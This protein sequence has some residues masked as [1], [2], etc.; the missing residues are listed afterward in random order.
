MKTIEIRKKVDDAYRAEARRCLEDE[1]LKRIESLTSSGMQIDE[2]YAESLAKDCMHRVK[3]QLFRYAKLHKM[4]DVSR[5]RP[6]PT[7]E[8]VF[9]RESRVPEYFDMPRCMLDIDALVPDWRESTAALIGNHI[10][11]TGMSR[12]EN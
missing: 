9:R 2:S 10:S 11:Q 7:S 8:G 3:R 12:I 4:I 5:T 6:H 1:V